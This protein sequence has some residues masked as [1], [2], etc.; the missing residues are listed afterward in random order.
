[1]EPGNL[2]CV[3][4]RV[5]KR[6]R[7]FVSVAVR[8]LPGLISIGMTPTLAQT[9][10]GNA[11]GGFGVWNSYCASCHNTGQKT[12]RSAGRAAGHITY[13]MNRGM[14]PADHP[15]RNLSMQQ[16]LDVAA[17][18]G[19]YVANPY[20]PVSQV[21]YNSELG[22]I[23]PF[24]DFELNTDLG[25]LSVVEIVKSPVKGTVTVAN[26]AFSKYFN[27]VPTPGQF[28]T[29]TF[30]FAVVRSI[31]DGGGQI[32]IRTVEVSIQA[33]VAPSIGGDDSAALQVG[34]SQSVSIQA[35]GIPRPEIAM[36]GTLP[37]GVT[38][39]SV[40]L[41]YT[42][43]TSQLTI[44]GPTLLVPAMDYPLTITAT[45]GILPNGSKPFLLRVVKRPNFINFSPP[46]I[47][48]IGSAAVPLGAT[49]YSG[50]AVT[51]STDNPSACVLAA[52]TVTPR[53]LGLCEI[54][55][56]QDGN[57][58]YEAAL[59]AV[60]TV[61]VV[62]QPQTVSFPSQA[63]QTFASAGTFVISPLA[64]ASSGLSITYSSETPARCSVSGT[65][66]T[67]VT[68]GTCIVRASQAGTSKIAAAFADQFIAVNEPAGGGFAR[69]VTPQLPPAVSGTP[70]QASLLFAGS[71]PVTAV[72]V[73]GLPAGLTATHNG[74]G[75]V[76]LSGIPAGDGTFILSANATSAAGTA[77]HTV[78]LTVLNAGNY[79]GNVAQVDAGGSHTCALVSGGVQCWGWNAYGQLG[80]DS[81]SS[82]SAGRL[83]IP[84]GAGATRL[85]AGDTHSCAVV[86]GGVQ[87]WGDNTGGKLGDGST[88]WRLSPV[89]AIAA[90]SGA[91]DVS[92]GITHTCAIVGGGVRCWGSNTYGQLG[93]GDL[94][95]RPAPFEVIPAGSGA[96]AIAA[97]NAF[98]CAVIAGGVKCWGYHGGVVLG[99]GSAVTQSSL[100]VQT[101]PPAS[102]VTAIATGN[103]HACAI[104]D[105]GLQCW[106]TN[107]YG[108]LG[109]GSNSGSNLP[110]QILPAASGV[111]GL[112]VGRFFT[113]VAMAG[114]VKCFG[115][116]INGE[117][118]I[119]SSVRS[120]VPVTTI[121]AGSGV[122]AVSN[123]ETHACA[124]VAG[125]V[126]CWGAN[127]IGQLGNAGLGTSWRV[128][129]QAVAA[130]S[131]ATSVST[132]TATAGFTCATLSGGISCWGDNT[133]GT[134]GNG[135]NVAS[136]MPVAVLPTGSG[137]TLI[138]AGGSHVC[139]VVAG[140]AKCWG[141]ASKY[142]LGN[143]GGS[144]SNVPVQV[145]GLTSGVTA[146]AAA[147]AHTCAVVNGGVKCWGDYIYG[148]L[149]TGN[150]DLTLGPVDVVNAGPG[151]GYTAVAAG[152]FH[153][154]GLVAGGALPGRQPGGAAGRWRY[155]A[156]SDTGQ[157]DRSRV[158]QQHDL[159]ANCVFLQHCQWRRALLG[160]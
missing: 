85:S 140:A 75:S 1:M 80:D 105:A 30:E 38:V 95:A 14:V 46:Q 37:P 72:A 70:Y 117:L 97:G 8:L 109:D 31:A 66:I 27:Y 99:D 147:S 126:R 63:T 79:A 108:Q 158:R 104:R 7:R 88:T 65:T 92:A 60:R 90:G 87:C 52:G 53:A 142:Q 115:D 15:A 77:T 96:T 89:V 113:C 4:R 3:M 57:A 112:G 116:N 83:S 32:S 136:I 76:A 48:V 119:E 137:A 42:Q 17:F 86:S 73:S 135:N 152:A 103:S 23:I 47:L 131:V 28:G 29:D 98:T 49:G 148:Q 33:P 71:L 40:P 91:S 43:D 61:Q 94:M 68:A 153:S 128:P 110:I 111:S 11:T 118:G 146:I 69:L 5:W 9:T 54:T 39:T 143:N 50:E 16:Y 10:F 36:L 24:A 141:S 93:A 120:N 114:G 64:T 154:C 41:Y 106:G 125:H 45:N 34:V 134:L 44:S 156:E 130:G 13:A 122:T 51:Y 25:R 124:I 56:R 59:P 6:M 35:Y 127:S 62:Q 121:T 129:V 100:P 101:I 139:S 55:A 20:R 145:A 160:R 12:V 19:L 18:I 133:A 151:S 107:V 123:G 138:T 102:G 81:L 2:A 159:V 22:I 155:H 78:A 74:S 132:G 150:F 21:S 157:C 144:S 82:S 26:S 84:P 149:G 58:V 67:M